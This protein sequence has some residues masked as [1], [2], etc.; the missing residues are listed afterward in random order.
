MMSKSYTPLSLVE[1]WSSRK[2]DNDL[3]PQIT[4]ISRTRLS[5]TLIPKKKKEVVDLVKK[6]LEESICVSLSFDL[7]MT[8]IN[9]CFFELRSMDDQEE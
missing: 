6:L 4:P 8:R 9:L 5:K 1:D 2:L 7:W 3:D